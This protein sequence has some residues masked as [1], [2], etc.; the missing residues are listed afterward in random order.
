VKR[1]V[2]AEAKMSGASHSALQ[3]RRIAAIYLPNLLSELGS[4][5]ATVRGAKPLGVV[6]RSSTEAQE[7]LSAAA[8]LD[9][10]N[11]AAYRF[12]VR[13]GQSIAEACAMVANLTVRKIVHGDVQA[14]LERLAEMAL[15]FG[16]TVSFSVPDTVWVDVTGASH[17]WGGEEQLGV[18]LLSRV[19]ALG[20]RARLAIASGPV[21]AKAFARWASLKPG[22]PE[23]H[24]VR[25]I[26]PRRT[27]EEFAELPVLALPLAEECRG[28]L[29]RLGLL[30]VGDLA[31]L[32]KS[33]IAARLGEQAPQILELC[34]GRDPEPLVPFRPPQTLVEKMSWDEPVAGLSPL[35]FVLRGLSAR[36]SARLSGRGQAAQT[37]LLTIEHDAINARFRGVAKTTELRFKLGSPLWREDEIC[38]VVASRLER[39]KLVAPSIGLRLE[40][41]KLTSAV[42]KQLELS[43]VM[44]GATGRVGEGEL[45]VVLAE[46]IADVGET[47][48]GV[49][50]LVD[51]HRPE[52]KSA[53]VAVSEPA[54]DERP[55]PRGPKKKLHKAVQQGAP[56]W[57]RLPNPPTRLLAEPVE[58]HAAL[59]VGATLAVG[60]ELYTLERLSF[61]QRLEAVE[62]WLREPVRRDYLRLWLKNPNGGLE[63]LVYVERETGRRFLQAVAD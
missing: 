27:A 30:S 9:A 35:A 63:A 46:L 1:Q 3:E 25:S 15:A 2:L 42:P 31:K 33:A 49:L 18:E 22:E 21:L 12:G 48:V 20:H 41:P 34:A 37:L 23:E 58:L 61:E 29:V 13:E 32:P 55:R 54:N 59:R 60:H 4:E 5:G 14:A 40:V 26:S 56:I 8:R 10:V 47:A 7:E 28:W 62:W 44:A 16:A 39:H 51:T 43:Q 6:L 11:A 38:R 36:V 17:L 50:S 19:R 53:L 45:A 57:S 52:L 24:G